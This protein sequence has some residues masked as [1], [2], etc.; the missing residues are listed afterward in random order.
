[1]TNDLT[2]QEEAR[3]LAQ[4]IFGNVSRESTNFA[5][6]LLDIYRQVQGKDFLLIHHPGGFGSK[7]LKHCLQWERSVVTG[8]CATIKRLGYTCLLTQYFRTNNGRLG[9]IRNLR[10]LFHLSSSKVDASTAQLKLILQHTKNLKVILIGVS[11]GAGFTNAIMQRLNGNGSVYSIELGMFFPYKDLRVIN[12]RTLAIDSNGTTPDLTFQGDIKVIAKNCLAAPIRWFKLQLK[13]TPMPVPWCVN[14][15]G[16][17]YD[18]SYPE[19]RHRIEN[20]IETNFG[21]NQK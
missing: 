9:L 11:S 3:R 1:M 5:N 21:N 4:Q 7:E 18:W 16:H 13:G 15:P 14:V 12:E 8:T 6:K 19:V 2:L 17:D 10:D 20:F